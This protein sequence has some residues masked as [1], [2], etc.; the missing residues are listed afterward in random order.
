MIPRH[1]ALRSVRRARPL[2]LAVAVI[3]ALG[4]SLGAACGGG[5]AGT[6][7]GMGGAGAGEVAVDYN[8]T[9]GSGDEMLNA[10]VA[11]EPDT[12]DPS[13]PAC[14]PGSI[15][16]ATGTCIPSC[17]ESGARCADDD[18]TQCAGFPPLQAY[19]CAVCCTVPDGTNAC[20]P[21]G[22]SESDCPAG[23]DCSYT[24]TCPDGVCA[25]D[26]SCSTCPIDCGPCAPSC[27]D[28]VC[29]AGRE[30]CTDCPEDCGA[31]APGC[32]DGT[33]TA[34]SETCESCPE[35]CGNCLKVLTWDIDAGLKRGK[36]NVEATLR[37]IADL[38]A[39]E[40]PDYVGL[41]SVDKNT[42]RSG[43][44]DEALVIARRVKMYKRFG[45]AFNYDGGQYGLAFLSRHPIAT[46]EKTL[47]DTSGEWAKRRILLK[48]TLD[49]PAYYTDFYL[50][51]TQLA[52][53]DAPRLA[54][55]TTIA[56]ELGL[57]ADALL[58]G[59][60]YEAPSGPAVA[61]LQ[62]SMNLIDLWPQY[63]AGQG[64]TTAKA[65]FDYVLAGL[66]WWNQSAA[67]TCAVVV[68]TYV[69]PA[70]GLSSHRPV[71]ALFQQG[72]MGIDCGITS[73]DGG[74][75]TG[76]IGT[77]NTSCAEDEDCAED[78][79]YRFCLDG[80]CAECRDGGDCH[81]PSAPT[82]DATHACR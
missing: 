78:P 69:K 2:G 46:M 37:S 3:A 42:S 11:G 50:G 71:V 29:T 18:P 66:N 67:G 36:G 45:A 53:A 4:W 7:G 44:R 55:A 14:A 62:Q 8:A 40:R 15:V 30:S 73:D 77:G 49:P 13:K 70:K 74:D 6:G 28:G 81:D 16:D 5:G 68:R 31:C 80:Y 56:G 26:E 79:V 60:L 12:K 17:F 41:Q 58:I 75:D 25:A 33:C 20:P 38:I 48:A 47:L 32:G 82:C 24:N 57:K 59:D 61:A 51:V 54:Q 65:R 22:C 35:D 52:H 27:G 64:L 34:G 9:T 39:L 19:D 72:F 63:G 23:E 43:K 10:D 21:G 76:A 1:V